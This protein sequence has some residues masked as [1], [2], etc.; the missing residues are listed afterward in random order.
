MGRRFDEDMP[1]FAHWPSL[2]HLLAGLADA[3][4]GGRTFLDRVPVAVAGKLG[5][6]EQR[7]VPAE[8]VSTPAWAAALVEPESDPPAQRLRTRACRCPS[9]G[10]AGGAA[11]TSE[12]SS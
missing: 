2:R 3:L 10:N 1:S 12:D 8:A 6:E 5:W 7:T 11:A 9:R 4:E